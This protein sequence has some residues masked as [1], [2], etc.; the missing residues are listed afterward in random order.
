MEVVKEEKSLEQRTQELTTINTVLTMMPDLVKLYPHIQPLID[1]IEGFIDSSLGDGEKMIVITK[2]N[3]LTR[4]TVFDTKKEF[5]LSN[6]MKIVTP[7]E[8][9]PVIKMY[10]KEEYKQKLINSIPMQVLK[11]KY[12]KMDKKEGEVST[13]PFASILSMLPK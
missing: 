10:K 12:D 1:T 11:E 4:A 9:S 7:I 13:N 2:I 6:N 5:T 8:G 3:G